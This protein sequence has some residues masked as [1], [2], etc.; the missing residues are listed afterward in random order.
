[1]WVTSYIAGAQVSVREIYITSIR[2]VYVLSHA[3]QFNYGE[4]IQKKLLGKFTNIIY[5]HGFR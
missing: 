1:M 4:L 3:H 2:N 5:L